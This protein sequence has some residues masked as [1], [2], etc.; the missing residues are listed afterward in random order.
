MTNLNEENGNN[1]VASNQAD[2]FKAVEKA[3]AAEKD[4]NDET[5]IV[6]PEVA[7]KVAKSDLKGVEQAIKDFEAIV[8]EE[9]ANA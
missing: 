8:E 3:V 9:I 6:D 7:A 5:I 1:E 4:P 2:K